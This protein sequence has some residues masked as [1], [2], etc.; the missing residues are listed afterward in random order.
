MNKLRLFYRNVSILF[1]YLPSSIKKGFE[2]RINEIKESRK[3]FFRIPN[4]PKMAM[5][6]SLIIAVLFAIDN[7]W[8]LSLFFFISYVIFKLWKIWIGGE[9]MKQYKEKHLIPCGKFNR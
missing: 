5:Q 1:D 4:S 8:M 3:S 2:R 6:L 7:R 9:P